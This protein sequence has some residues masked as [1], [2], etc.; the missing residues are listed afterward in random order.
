MA[1]L[2]KNSER[3][4]RK[5]QTKILRKLHS[6]LKNERFGSCNLGNLECFKNLGSR[7]HPLRAPVFPSMNDS[8]R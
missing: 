8:P 2:D 3:L 5:N 7:P 1:K 6:T 4:V